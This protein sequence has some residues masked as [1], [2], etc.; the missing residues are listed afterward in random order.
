M[1]YSYDLRTRILEEVDRGEKLLTISKTFKVNI[2]TIYKWRKQ[3][4]ETGSIKPQEKW[5][6]GHSHKIQDLKAF[7]K[8]VEENPGRTLVEMAEAFGG[9]QRMTIQRALKKIGFTR[10]KDLRICG[11][12]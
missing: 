10:K 5:Q 7:R 2:K 12:Q 8:F 4:K 6:K 9:V 1:A 3:R 11:A